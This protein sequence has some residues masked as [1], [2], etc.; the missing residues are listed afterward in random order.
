MKKCKE[1]TCQKPSRKRG[2]CNMHYG[3]WRNHGTVDD[4]LPRPERECS[5]DGCGKSVHGRGWCGTHYARWLQHGTVAD[6]PSPGERFRTFFRKRGPDDCWMWLGETDKDGYGCFSVT[7]RK[8]VRAHRFSYELHTGKSLGDKLIDHRCHKTY[9][10]NPA[11]LRPVTNKQNMENRRK[12]RSNTG[13]RG[14]CKLPNGRFQATLEHNGK[15]IHV[16]SFATA[17]EANEAVI[18]ARNQHYTHN[19]LDRRTG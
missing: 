6:P 18:A 8:R 19:D 3:R 10:V 13:F 4:P 5:V 2:W 17:E 15:G 9:C 12:I 16:G 1:D 11:H 14:V 7:H